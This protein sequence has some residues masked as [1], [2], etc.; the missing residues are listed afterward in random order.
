MSFSNILQ[1]I[2]KKGQVTLSLASPP[3]T[4]AKQAAQIPQSRP[5]TPSSGTRVTDPV[6]AQLKAA[7]KAE[8]LRKEQEAREKKGL[9]PKAASGQKPRAKRSVPA[10]SSGGVRSNGSKQNPSSKSAQK[11]PSR[12]TTT[13]AFTPA[14]EKKPKVS[15]TELMKK[16]SGIDQLKLSIAIKQKPKVAGPVSKDKARMPSKGLA[17]GRRDASTANRPSK[18]SGQA[19]TS[20]EGRSATSSLSDRRKS[21]PDRATL[22]TRAPLPTR[23]P[24][25]LLEEKL[26]SKRGRPSRDRLAPDDG[27]DDESD[28]DSFIASDED[29]HQEVGDYDRDEIWS[30]FNRG[31]KRQHYEYDEDSDDMEATGAEIWEEENRSK[32]T[33]MIEDRR[34]MEEEARL[35]AMKRARKNNGR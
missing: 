16:A 19:G 7:R 32:R 6:V 10:T 21:P 25:S 13:P 18:Q 2:Q 14:P 30:I 34:E 12:S 22:Q 11:A 3:P 8:Q 15:F 28:L 33:A 35:A 31:K 26:K 27:D 4:A 24:S 5:T 9:P 1:R 23:Q 17:P 20:R 29:E